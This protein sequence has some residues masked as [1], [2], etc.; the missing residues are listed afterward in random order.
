MNHRPGASR[1]CQSRNHG[2]KTWPA[3]LSRVRT[4]PFGQRKQSTSCLTAGPVQGTGVFR[5]HP[6][7]PLAPSPNENEARGTGGSNPLSS[8]GE[9]LSNVKSSSRLRMAT[10]APLFRPCAHC[11]AVDRFRPHRT[12]PGHRT[13]ALVCTLAAA[14]LFHPALM[15]ADSRR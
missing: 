13:L 7:Q 1:P 10:R 11:D 9:S 3:V 8:R 6:D 15:G 12:G 4:K 2:E 14:V 5:D